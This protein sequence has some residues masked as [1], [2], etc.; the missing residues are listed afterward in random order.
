MC[1]T[2]HPNQPKLTKQEIQIIIQ[3]SQQNKNPKPKRCTKECAYCQ[4]VIERK[5]YFLNQQTK[6]EAAKNN[7]EINNDSN[8][9][10]NIN[11]EETINIKETIEYLKQINPI[12]VGINIL[13]TEKDG[14]C[15]INSI[16][17]TLGID[18]KYNMH[19]R[20]VIANIIKGAKI[21]EDILHSLNYNTK[22]EYINYVITDKNWCG[23]HELTYLALQYNILI[24]IYSPPTQY[25]NYD[26]WYFI[27]DQ[28]KNK[29][30]S[31]LLLHYKESED[32]TRDQTQHYSGYDISKLKVNLN[33]IKNIILE[34]IIK[35][36][37]NKKQNN[38]I[39]QKENEI[40]ILVWNANSLKDYTKKLFLIETMLVNKIHIALIQETM[41]KDKD[42]LYINGYRIYRS[43]SEYRRGTA[44][45]ISNMI[46]AQTYI[47][48]KCQEG[49]YI[50]MKIKN[51]ET[52]TELTISNIYLEP[53]KEKVFEEI[54]PEAIRN[55]DCIAGDLNKAKTGMTVHSNVYHVYN[56]GEKI[57]T[58]EIDHKISDHPILIFKKRINLPLK[59]DTEN[60]IILDNKTVEENNLKIYNLINTHINETKSI[61]PHKTIKIKSFE[62][63]PNNANNWD[64]FEI[65]KKQNI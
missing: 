25:K 63:Q 61:E 6:K 3:K 64:N 44:I 27:Y 39:N 9:Q 28:R 43:N 20:K 19:L 32:N 35:Q 45:L 53:D 18:T 21:N 54:I 60:K 17:K 50:K 10:P 16:L 36:E 33:R 8:N 56:I 30:N 52:N 41:L 55:S 24:A 62:C 13:E 12:T 2:C 37:E 5:N 1:K 23:Y 49:R 26:Q 14:N 29:A 34:E 31:V 47:T 40:N 65:I 48:M 57:E 42:K 4:K 51:E 58:I 15:L 7:E 46:N 11:T 59:E 22:E 38:P